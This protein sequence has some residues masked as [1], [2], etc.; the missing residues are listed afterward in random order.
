MK[1]LRVRNVH[2]ALP[3]AIDLLMS[4]GIPRETRNGKVWQCPEP[5]TT[6]YEN[7]R[8]RV[9]FWPE[10]NAN[11]F[12]HFYES[13]WMLA[14]RNDLH[15]LE[16]IVK[17]MRDF[18]QEDGT[19]HGAYG[20]RWR[21]SDGGLD[22]LPLIARRLREDPTDR[23]QV[24]QMWSAGLDLPF[25]AQKRDLPCNHAA[26]FQV[27]ALG[28]LDMFVHNRSNDIIWGAYGANAVHF[29]YLQ[30]YMAFAVGVP[31]GMYWQISTNWHGYQE[32]VEPLKDLRQW[33]RVSNAHKIAFT[34]YNPYLSADV[35]PFKMI[36]TSIDTW[37]EDL[38]L[39][40]GAEDEAVN[41]Y[42]DPFFVHVAAPMMAVFHMQ[43][44]GRLQAAH[45]HARTIMATDWRLAVQEWLLRKIQRR[46]KAE[47]DGPDHL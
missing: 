8:E 39:F 3:N 25:Q 21:H 45:K 12:F 16:R 40:M 43:K 23:R 15:P 29:S 6:V 33:S 42:Q 34:P 17:R 35:A 38:E 27:N 1:T 4:W 7:P 2:E 18:A 32:T 14:G 26:T 31:V 28:S 13:L 22:Q 47:D 20:F 30:E 10:R 36:N 11:P 37:L 41:E 9:I 19:L 5:V 46:R 24:L 44:A